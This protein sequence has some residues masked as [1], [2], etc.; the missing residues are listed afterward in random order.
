V[1]VRRGLGAVV[2]ATLLCALVPACTSSTSGASSPHASGTITVF[3]ASSLTEAFTALGRAFEAA[4]PG[5]HVAFDFGAS[6]ALALQIDQG[7]P[8]DVFA[9]AAPKNMQQVV[10][11][12]GAKTPVNFVKNVMAVAVPPANPARI[13]GVADLARRGV[14]VALCEPQVPCGATAQQVFAKANLSVRPSTL[15]PDVKSTLA[16]V[17]LG[18]VDAGVVY[19]TDV[20][21]AGSK[22]T[23]IVIP[24]NYNASTEYPIATLTE[25]KNGATAAAF[26]AFVRSAQG[27]ALLLAAG[28]EAP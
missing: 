6:S 15:E 11:A 5:T 1:S 24:P 4:H 23:G 17:E 26:V 13:A 21:A 27:Q 22:V 25:S 20:R 9:S 19:V 7:A 10:S 3:A 28:F 8:A 14:K 2:G 16:K 18:E 12:G